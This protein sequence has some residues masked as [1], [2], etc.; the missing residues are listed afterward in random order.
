MGRRKIIKVQQFLQIPF[1]AGDRER[2]LTAGM[3]GYVSKPIGSGE[4]FREI[5]AFTQPPRPAGSPA[6]PTAESGLGPAIEA[7]VIDLAVKA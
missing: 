2:C 3:D 4:S 6:A 5:Y 1:Y 7:T